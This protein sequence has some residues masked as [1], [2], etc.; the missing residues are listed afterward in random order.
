MK[1]IKLIPIVTI[2]LLTALFF[3]DALLRADT[4]FLGGIDV[5]GYYYYLKSY[6]IDRL[7]NLSFPLWNAYYYSGHPFLANPDNFVFYPFSILFLIFDLPCAFT[8]NT[9][10]HIVFAGYGTYLFV[11]KITCSKLSG[12]CSAIVFGFNSYMIHRIFAGHINYIQAAALFPWI[13]YFLEIACRTLKFNYFLLLSFAYSF[14]LLS[15]IPQTAFY[16]SLTMILYFIFSAFLD[17]QKNENLH[18]LKVYFFVSAI[19][20]G[21]LFSAIQ[22]LPSIEFM[23]L[24]DRATSTYSFST[25]YSFPPILFLSGIFPHIL[26]EVVKDSWWEFSMYVG[27][28]SI[29]LSFFSFF[30]WKNKYTIIFVTLGILSITAMLGSYTPI[31]KFYYSCIPGFGFFRMPARANIVLI[32]SFAVLSGI[33]LKALFTMRYLR[34]K[35]VSM[36]LIAVFFFLITIYTKNLFF[37]GIWHY[38]IVDNLPFLFLPLILY[39]LC[40]YIPKKYYVVA[41]ILVICF[42]FLDLFVNLKGS[43]PIINIEKIKQK[44]VIEETVLQ[45]PGLFRVAIPQGGIRGMHYKYFDVNG[46]QPIVIGE[47]YDFMHKMSN[48][49]TP[50]KPRVRLSD[51][52][53]HQPR[54]FLGKLFN[55]KYYYNKKSRKLVRQDHFERAFWVDNVQIEPDL[56]KQLSILKSGQINLSK[57]A[58]VKKQP[59]S[60]SSLRNPPAE[61]EY[62]KFINYK[63]EMI[64]IESNSYQDRYL[65]L[66]ELF[67]PGWKATIDNHEVEI[68]QAN[69]LL[70]SVAI[71]RGVHNIKFTYI[72]NSFYYGLLISIL[73]LLIST[74]SF[75]WLSVK[76]KNHYF[77]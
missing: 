1:L 68:V 52:I 45:T 72:P 16:I 30:N 27:I 5:A 38:I 17:K 22:L 4:H 63:N 24:S 3:S 10:F 51:E 62:L 31:Y 73:S 21:V 19:F 49:P 35:R 37:K 48:L 65:I 42:L 46:Y 50:E 9:L 28:S 20:L 44:N 66:S 60:V 71:P 47:Y 34:H 59:R 11:N 75:L 33:G 2:T 76:R 41:K 12:I 61:K 6:A 56:E 25:H 14:L 55:V 23:L 7:S 54:E 53:F 15:G 69:Y 58:L 77:L 32:F 36:V 43:I 18:F 74:V 13:I 67:Y 64:E 40:T 8:A 26:P 70:R 39:W 29:V 57:T